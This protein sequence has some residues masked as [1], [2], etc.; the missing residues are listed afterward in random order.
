M[1]A[2]EK[3]YLQ[4]KLMREQAEEEERKA[5]ERLRKRKNQD[6]LVEQMKAKERE[7][8]RREQEEMYERRA[9]LLAEMEYRRKIDV[10][11]EK[12]QKEVENLKKTKGMSAFAQFNQ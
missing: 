12:A 3:A 5:L 2:E 6:D 8:R 7:R 10:E 9:A 11:K 4:A 1:L